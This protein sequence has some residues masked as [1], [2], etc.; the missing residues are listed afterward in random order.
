[1]LLV[2]QVVPEQLQY[3]LIQQLVH[4]D[5]AGAVAEGDDVKV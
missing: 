2:E 4:E 5:A 1:V 3:G